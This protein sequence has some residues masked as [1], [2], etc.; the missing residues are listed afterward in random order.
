MVAEDRT[1]WCSL[2]ATAL[3]SG[4]EEDWTTRRPLT[5]KITV[6]HK[7]EEHTAVALIHST[8]P[9]RKRFNTY[10]GVY[11]WCQTHVLH[12]G[13]ILGRASAIGLF[14]TASI[15]HSIKEARRRAGIC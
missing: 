12:C 8:K 5:T 15:L 11:L 10:D 2:G 1:N 14:N 6:D 9:F 13:L 4:E 7:L 3:I